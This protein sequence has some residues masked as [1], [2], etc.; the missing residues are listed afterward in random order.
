[1]N[2]MLAS[3]GYPW[4]VIPVEKREEY[5]KSLEIASVTQ[6]ISAFAKFMAYLVRENM[7]GQPVAHLPG[8]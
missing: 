7:N 5:M 6:D 1:M 8:K 4:T 3:G 2:I